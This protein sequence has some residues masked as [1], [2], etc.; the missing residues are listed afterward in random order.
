[1]LELA[2]VYKNTVYVYVSVDRRY[3]YNVVVQSEPEKK[4]RLV[5]VT[6]YDHKYQYGDQNHQPQSCTAYNCY[7]YRVDSMLK[8][9]QYL[10][11]ACGLC[12]NGIGCFTDLQCHV[13]EK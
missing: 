11:D 8:H 13:K 5:V 12:R 1:M 6:I 10:F 4:T 7:N 3:E 9:C 2:K